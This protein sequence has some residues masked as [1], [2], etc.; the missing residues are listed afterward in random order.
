M[1]TSPDQ[2]S[3]TI[4]LRGPW[5]CRLR[6]TGPSVADCRTES[7]RIQ[8]PNDLAS[9]IPLGFRGS[10]LLTRSF[11]QPTGIDASVQVELVGDCSYPAHVR[12]NGQNLQTVPHTRFRHSV[13]AV[14]QRRNQL[15]IELVIDAVGSM[16]QPMCEVRLCIAPRQP[17]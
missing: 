1:E 5:G 15:E 11:H 13:T 3:H 7:Q 17:E 4:R 16:D 2:P 6:P 9:L 10:L 14:L 8:L 12:L